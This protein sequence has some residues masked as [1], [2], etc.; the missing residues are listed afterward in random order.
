MTSYSVHTSINFLLL[1]TITTK[2]LHSDFHLGILIAEVN[3]ARHFTGIVSIHIQLLSTV[4]VLDR[5]VSFLI[6]VIRL[7]FLLWQIQ[8]SEVGENV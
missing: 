7:L 1:L 5:V 6:L 8:P 4:T 3:L 2:C